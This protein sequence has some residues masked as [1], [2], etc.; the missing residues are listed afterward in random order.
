MHGNSFCQSITATARKQKCG[1][2]PKVGEKGFVS[3]KVGKGFVSP[4]VG[5]GFALSLIHI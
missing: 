5:K 2:S 1:V 4:K 3:P